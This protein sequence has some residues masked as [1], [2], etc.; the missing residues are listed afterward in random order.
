[1]QY[2]DTRAT[3]PR[4]ADPDQLRKISQA[5]LLRYKKAALQFTTWATEFELDPHTAEEFDDLLVE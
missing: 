4:R 1:M 3:G 5:S 2:Q